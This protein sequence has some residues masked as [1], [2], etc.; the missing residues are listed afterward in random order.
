M[1]FSGLNCQNN[2]QADS[3]G[4]K[5]KMVP[6]TDSCSKPSSYIFDGGN[7]RVTHNT[8]SASSAVYSQL[9]PTG[10]VSSTVIVDLAKSKQ[11]SCSP[12]GGSLD[13][14]ETPAH[15]EDTEDRSWENPNENN[16]QASESEICENN[17]MLV[18]PGVS[19][20][21]R[22]YI[23][24]QSVSSNSSEK[25]G[26][27]RPSVTSE[28]SGKHFWPA[29]SLS[30]RQLLD[31]GA[32]DE[33][34]ANHIF[35]ESRKEL[36]AMYS[37]KLREKELMVASLKDQLRLRTMQK[38][39]ELLSKDSTS[40]GDSYFEEI[41]YLTTELTGKQDEIGKVKVQLEGYEE[42]KR[43]SDYLEEQAGGAVKQMMSFQKENAELKELLAY[44]GTECEMVNAASHR[45]SNETKQYFEECCNSLRK[46]RDE[47]IAMKEKQALASTN[48]IS[49]M[50]ARLREAESH[51]TEVLLRETAG[52]S[53]GGTDEAEG[54]TDEAEGGNKVDASLAELRSK[55]ISLEEAL[56]MRNGL[57][58]KLKKRINAITV[59]IADS[60]EVEQFLPSLDLSHQ[61]HPQQLEMGVARV[62]RQNGSLKHEA[63]ADREA[64]LEAMLAALRNKVADRDASIE[65][66]QSKYQGIMKNFSSI[67]EHSKKVNEKLV[68]KEAES[69][70]LKVRNSLNISLFHMQIFVAG[71]SVFFL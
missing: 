66:S 47:A 8:L 28:G 3:M 4:S 22:E 17:R 69:D 35:R 21:T 49:V 16:T 42:L 57:I 27:D 2:R 53:A 1:Q 11:P 58:L 18:K 63:D 12:H 68:A 6:G 10:S 5:A 31:H 24:S 36:E 55:I 40:E 48:E 50:D 54:G 34:S 25:S 70:E 65:K 9:T 30:R 60:E 29:D 15:Y 33:S 61:P 59:P 38:R 23:K 41:V 51:L 32:F 19:I 26:S 56:E 67:S 62:Q 20:N 37:S 43:R 46:E 44:P 45:I 71:R 39:S 13:D 52:V 64:E 14:R 7:A